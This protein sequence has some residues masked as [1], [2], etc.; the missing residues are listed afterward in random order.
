MCMCF[1][2][3]TGARHVGYYGGMNYGFGYMGI[4]F[5]GGEWHGH[6]FAYNTAV[7]NVNRTVIRNTYV[8]K[9]IINNVTMINNNRVAYTGGPGGIRHDPTSQER[10]AMREPHAAPDADPAAALSSGAHGT[11]QLLQS[12]QRPSAERG[13]RAAACRPRVSPPSARAVKGGARGNV[14]PRR[15]P[16]QCATGSTGSCRR[17]PGSHAGNP[18]AVPRTSRRRGPSHRRRPMPQ[19]QQN[20]PMPQP[21]PQIGQRRNP[22]QYRPAPQPQPNHPAPQ[23]QSQNHGLSREYRP[24]PQPQP[25]GASPGACNRSSAPRRNRVLSRSP[26]R[27]TARPPNRGRNRS[28]VPLRSRNTQPAPQARPSPVSPCAASQARTAVSAGPAIAPGIAA[29]SRPHR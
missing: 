17:T 10:V 24:A 28:R 20:R 22:T 2:P 18:T 14:Q 27:N 3:A 5:V 21:Q 4:G 13:R 7:V 6:D 29:E 9:T 8:N 25:R 26:S 23:P 11:C 15:H 19:P 1:T 16:W 12:Q